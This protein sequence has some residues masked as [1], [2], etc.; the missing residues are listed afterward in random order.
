MV[1]LVVIVGSKMFCL[2]VN[3]LSQLANVAIELPFTSRTLII[4]SQNFDYY[5]RIAH[6]KLLHR[7]VH[8]EVLH[9]S[10]Y[11]AEFL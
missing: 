8:Y 3:L 6:Y 7:I 2:Y 9:S 4:I 5:K 1:S 11:C 10:K